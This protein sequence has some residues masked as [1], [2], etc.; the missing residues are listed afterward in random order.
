MHVRGEAPPEEQPPIFGGKVPLGRGTGGLSLR[1][2]AK[3][4]YITYLFYLFYLFFTFRVQNNRE[5][6]S[7]E[8]QAAYGWRATRM[9]FT[10][11]AALMHSKEWF[12]IRTT[13]NR[14]E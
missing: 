4:I 7:N 9:S 6:P 2:V 12:L 11:P 10:N 14:N 8:I 13:R 5:I 1:T 3:L